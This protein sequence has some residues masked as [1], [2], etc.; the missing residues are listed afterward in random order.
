MLCKVA[1]IQ[2]LVAKGKRHRIASWWHKSIDERRFM[3]SGMPKVEKGPCLRTDS[4]IDDIRGGQQ[5]PAG[6]AV[7]LLPV[8]ATLARVLRQPAPACVGACL[9]RHPRRHRRHMHDIVSQQEAGGRAKGRGAASG[10]RSPHTGR[11]IVPRTAFRLP[12]I[13]RQAARGRHGTCPS[14]R[15]AASRPARHGHDPVHAGA[16]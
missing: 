16:E 10:G 2:R 9:V 6:G 7:R 11:A 5:S 12:P 4:P 1:A 15:P 14:V 3:P 8:R 13:D